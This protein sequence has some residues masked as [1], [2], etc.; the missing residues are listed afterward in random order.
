MKRAAKIDDNQSAIVQ[1]LRAIGCSVQS[2]AAVGK[3]VP[4]LLVGRRGVN[5]LIEIKDAAKTASRRKLTED[6]V[7]WHKLW[8]GQI[9]VAHTPA[10]AEAVVMV[11][12]KWAELRT[13]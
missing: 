7:I 13:A 9:S 4:D 11:A 2:L 3:G 12:E 5:S 1:H 8:R 10:E 6:Q